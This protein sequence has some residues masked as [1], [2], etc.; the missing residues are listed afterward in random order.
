[1][2]SFGR[3]SATGGSVMTG[4]DCFIVGAGSFDG[5]SIRPKEGDLIIAADGGYRYLNKLG[6]HPQVLM[7]D[8]DSLQ[9]VPEHEHLLRHSPLKDDTDM[10]L[11]AAYGA[12]QGCRR[13]FLYGGLGGRLDHTLAN[14]QLLTGLSRAGLEA[15]LIGE[16]TIITAITDE[17]ICFGVQASGIISVFCTGEKATGI[18]E[19]GLKYCLA[20]ASLTCDRTLGISNEFLGQESSIEVR[21]GTLQILWEEHCGLPAKRMKAE[22]SA[23]GVKMNSDDNVFPAQGLISELGWNSMNGKGGR[24]ANYAGGEEQ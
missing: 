23:P 2:V 9:R 21:N 7:G 3:T 1:M 11:A 20:D 12:E 19:R 22:G 18:W 17:K 5:M 24:S 15:Y 6:I 13:F 14:L 4:R 8:F 16:K 10:A